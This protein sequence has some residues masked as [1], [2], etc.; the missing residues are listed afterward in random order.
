M[1]GSCWPAWAGDAND[2]PGSAAVGAEGL[3]GWSL[4]VSI[5][6]ETQADTTKSKPAKIANAEGLIGCSIMV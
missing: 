2:D 3:A 1:L 4:A 5:F 6:V